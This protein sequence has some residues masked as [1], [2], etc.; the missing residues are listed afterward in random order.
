MRGL[1]SGGAMFEGVG[2]N[3][4]DLVSVKSTI[5]QLLTTS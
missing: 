4:N 2:V 5:G 3:V 1:N